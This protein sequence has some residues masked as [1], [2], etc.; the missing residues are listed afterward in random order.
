M[1][2]DDDVKNGNLGGSFQIETSRHRLYRD[3]L[4]CSDPMYIMRI[5]DCP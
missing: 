5:N 3:G 1:K 2:W 4:L